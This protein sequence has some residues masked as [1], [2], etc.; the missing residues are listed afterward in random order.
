MKV[1]SGRGK[2]S[3][4]GTGGKIIKS[5]PAQNENDLKSQENCRK[6]KQELDNKKTELAKYLSVFRK[7]RKNRKKEGKLK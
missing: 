4:R 6:E 1:E 5:M 2:K 7:K 3:I